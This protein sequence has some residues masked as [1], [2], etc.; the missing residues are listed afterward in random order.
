MDFKKQYFS[1]W[2]KAWNF[3]K[4]WCNNSGSEQ[5]WDAIVQEARELMNQSEF[6]KSLTL[7]V[8]NELEKNDKER[9]CLNG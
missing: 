3:H 9:R 5:E 7:A 1:Q 2:G 8:I 4:K 6:L